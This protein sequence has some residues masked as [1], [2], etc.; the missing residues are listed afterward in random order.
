MESAAL[1]RRLGY[2]TD[3]VGWKCLEPQRERLHAVIPKSARTVFGRAQRREGDAGY[4]APWGLIVPARRS[5]LLAD[6]P[7]TKTT[8]SD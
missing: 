6:V 5:D 7:R 3:L 2:C 8:R 1:I 4:I